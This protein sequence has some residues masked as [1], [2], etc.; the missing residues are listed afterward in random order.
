[1]QPLG[2]A[3][4][5]QSTTSEN[6]GPALSDLRDQLLQI[7]LREG[8]LRLEEPVQLR[9]GQWSQDFIDGKRALARG[10][11]LELACRYILERLESAGIDFDAAGGLT[12]GADHFSHGV[13]LVG[14]KRWFVVRKQAKGRGTNRRV[15]GAELGPGVRVLLIDDVV[16]TGGSIKDAWQC[17]ADTGAEIVAAVTLVDRGEVAAP[18]FAEAGVPYFPLLT[19]QDLG[20]VPIGA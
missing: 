14:R 7:V 4:F 1:M 5:G 3:L 11:D 10:E 6:P 19:Y 20:I 9:S 15:E 13:A 17:V 2:A 8:Y 18:F 12:M 16:S